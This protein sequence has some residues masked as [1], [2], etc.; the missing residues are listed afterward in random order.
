MPPRHGST[1]KPRPM[2][3]QQLRYVVST[4]DEGTMTH[5]AAANHVAQPALSRAIRALEA[6]L[7]VTVFDRK[8]RGVRLTGD[9]AEV[10]AIARRILA[11]VDRLGAV[12]QK[13]VLRVCA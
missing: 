8:G 7:G 1:R 11:D 10:V 12:G 4:A 6:E 5:A 9:G 2:N 3:L 13:Q